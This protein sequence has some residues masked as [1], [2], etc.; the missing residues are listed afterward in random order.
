M[1]QSEVQ[2]VNFLISNYRGN[3]SETF[4]DGAIH[5]GNVLSLVTQD[6]YVCRVV[7]VKFCVDYYVLIYI[8]CWELLK[9][10]GSHSSLSLQFPMKVRVWHV[11]SETLKCYDHTHVALPKSVIVE[12][13]VQN[14]LQVLGSWLL[15][16]RD[17]DELSRIGG[18]LGFTSL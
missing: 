1:V 9:P 14:H 15:L 4:H 17:M 12:F 3:V 13:C 16:T 18:L 7:C 6:A 11:V 2:F 8:H 10:E 5:Y